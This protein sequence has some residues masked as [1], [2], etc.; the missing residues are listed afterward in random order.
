MKR[1]NRYL[2][3]LAS[4]SLL[5]MACDDNFMNEVPQTS[6]TVP[7]FFNTVEDL[8]MYTN[9][10]YGLIPSNVNVDADSDNVTGVSA[11]GGEISETWNVVM[12]KL[13]A[14]NADG[15]GDW[16]ALR[17]INVLLDNVDRVTGN[18][19]E[20]AHYTG[21]ARYCRAWWYIRV[22][23]R[24]SH[25]PWIGHALGS[26]DPDVYRGS[27]PREFVVERIME[28]LEYAA[29]NMLPDLGNKTRVH[30][31]CALA[32]LSRFAL[33]EGTY[34]KYH[35]ELALA[36]TANTFLER[37]ASA[38]EEIMSSGKFDIPAGA[39]ED[40]GGGIYGAPEYRKLYCSLNLSG[41]PDIIQWTEYREGYGSTP[42]V[43]AD[44]FSL[45]RSLQEN[46]LTLD[47]KA[48][49]TVTG[50][51]TKPYYETFV[52]RDPRMAETFVYP[53][54]HEYMVGSNKVP[55]LNMPDK[56]GYLQAKCFTNRNTSARDYFEGRPI[57]RFSEVLLNYAEAKAE[58]GQDPQASATI[59]KLRARVGM[60]AFDVAREVDAKLRTQYP[61]VSDVLRAIRRERRTELAC[62]GFRLSDIY[63]WGLG[64]RFLDVDAK[65]GIWI[66]AYGGY[67]VDGD[68]TPDF[69]IVARE[70]D[71]PENWTETGVIEWFH[72]A[73]DPSMERGKRAETFTLSEGTH[74][75]IVNYEVDQRAFRSPKDYYRPINITHFTMNPNLIQAHGWE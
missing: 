17:R 58:L 5:F 68:G 75:Y 54:A 4:L 34:R 64:E 61:G 37:A 10:L 8:K 71:I 18:A 40:F 23:K 6:I 70:S 51:E 14:D 60:P 11:F 74:G 38:A 45:S 25:V 1:I 26:A 20:I 62:E 3:A 67:D 59:N 22:V 55:A 24:N 33:Y 42:S 27:D 66:P 73:D 65:Q 36:S 30:K 7:A 46:Y 9:G 53:G 35:P 48:Y 44:F 29:A 72:F 12:G 15:I 31:Y 43:H 52:G 21:F 63:R 32:L 50:Y 39:H 13:S 47:G 49:S 69:A 2:T 16:G 28:D 56:G 19:A 57:F 41:Y